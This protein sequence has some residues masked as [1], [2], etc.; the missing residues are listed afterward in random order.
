MVVEIS[1]WG[2]EIMKLFVPESSRDAVSKKVKIR[3]NFSSWP[4]IFGTRFQ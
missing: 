4:I 1:D 2:H 3:P